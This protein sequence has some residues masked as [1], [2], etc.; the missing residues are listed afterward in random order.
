MELS[1]G[2]KRILTT[3]HASS[4]TWH[5]DQDVRIAVELNQRFG[6]DVACRAIKE[7]DSTQ[8]MNSNPIHPPALGS[9]LTGACR[10]VK[11]NV[12]SKEP[13]ANQQRPAAYKPAE[14][15][16]GAEQGLTSEQIAE[17]TS[18]YKRG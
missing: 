14:I 4:Y 17:A 5:G 11:D 16:F 9:W 7:S 3:L 13:E 8:K 10:R 18:G 12:P 15:N 6:A 1:P 2:A